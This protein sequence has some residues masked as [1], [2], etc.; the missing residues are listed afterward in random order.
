LIS[1][2]HEYWV[3]AKT[4][5]APR[6]PAQVR[7]AIDT[8]TT[9]GLAGIGR[10]VTAAAVVMSISFAAL[11]PAHISFMRMLGLGLTLA[12]LADATLVRMVLVPAFIHL[13]GA[14]TWW[15]PKPIARLHQRFA[16]GRRAADV[17]QPGLSGAPTESAETAAPERTSVPP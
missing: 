4:A 11:I 12:V 14:W 6:T 13:A 7:A 10:V 5:A 15:A 17:D 8:S 16:P 1:R 3:A 9:L 2:I